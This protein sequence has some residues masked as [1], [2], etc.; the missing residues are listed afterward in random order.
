MIKTTRT[1]TLLLST[2]VPLSALILV[3]LPAHAEAWMSAG[4][5]PASE[6]G[7][8]SLSAMTQGTANFAWGLGIVFN[9]EFAGN[10]VLDYPVPHD[11][12]TSLGN[13][14]TGN[15]IGLDAV[16]FPAG[17]SSWRPYA[18]VGLYYNKRVDVAQS[19]VTGWLYTNEEKSNV[20]ASFEAG[21]QYR[22]VDGSLFGLG[23][24]S[25]RGVYLTVG[26]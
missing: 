5:A 17:V 16:W 22:S 1:S 13:R 2:V 26:W 14:R 18:G 20:Q 21:I 11:D 3:T 23:Y 24:H 12:F 7:G 25:I 6:G 10:D 15:A 8:F 4:K 19:N 9:G